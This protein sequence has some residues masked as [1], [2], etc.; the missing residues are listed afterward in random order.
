MLGSALIAL[1]KVGL[2][3]HPDG[4]PVAYRGINA[5]ARQY[6]TECEGKLQPENQ[7]RVSQKFG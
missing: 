3:P 6:S 7:R 4:V 1:E 2:T 5:V